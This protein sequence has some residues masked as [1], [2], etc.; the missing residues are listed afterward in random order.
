MDAKEIADQKAVAVGRAKLYYNDTEGTHLQHSE[1]SADI[2]EHGHHQHV[3]PRV[4]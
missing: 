2:M 3:S 1:A 4:R